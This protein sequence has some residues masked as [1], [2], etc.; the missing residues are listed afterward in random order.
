MGMPRLWFHRGDEAEKL[1]VVAIAAGAIHVV[2][3]LLMSIREHIRHRNTKHA[4]ESLGLLLG[5]LAV[6][7]GALGYG[8]VDPFTTAPA[9]IAAVFLIIASVVILVGVSR[10][11]AAVHMLEVVSLVGN[12]LSYSRLM[13][14]G[15]ASVVLADVANS[16]VGKT[17]NIVVGIVLAVIIHC[18]NIALG[19]FS[20]TIHS[21]RL[22]YVE[23]LPKFYSPEGRLYKPFR[24]EA[25]S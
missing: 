13:A 1:L 21:L 16:M 6:G 22:N 7:V 11:M 15:I 12:V 9:R 18:I 5:L 14:L 19:I 4:G 20:P 2:L 8:G 3:S 23:F 10:A 25:L 24:K 17:G